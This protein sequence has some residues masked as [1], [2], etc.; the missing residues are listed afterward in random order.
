MLSGNRSH[1]AQTIVSEGGIEV[2]TIV[3]SSVTEVGPFWVVITNR[4]MAGLSVEADF[5]GGLKA[6]RGIQQITKNIIPGEKVRLY[7]LYSEFEALA[8]PGVIAAL[9]TLIE[10]QKSSGF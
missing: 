7:G 10:L 6:I 5:L 1:G 3:A 9:R 8:A 4:L 2:G